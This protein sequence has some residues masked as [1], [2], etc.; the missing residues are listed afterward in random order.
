MCTEFHTQDSS[1]FFCL[2]Y[3]NSV[4]SLILVP[5]PVV[6]GKPLIVFSLAII[7][8]T[9][10]YMHLVCENIF[11]HETCI[12]YIAVYNSKKGNTVV[13]WLCVCKGCMKE[14]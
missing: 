13:L 12:Y 1:Q 2:W 10:I 6:H 5:S 11:F 3:H 7:G 8:F 4:A 9:Y 14:Y